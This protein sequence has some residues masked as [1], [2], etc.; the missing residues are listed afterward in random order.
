MEL[1]SGCYTVLC[2]CAYARTLLTAKLH[3]DGVRITGAPPQGRLT[4][5]TPSLALAMGAQKGAKTKGPRTTQ[6][7]RSF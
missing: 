1:T 3:S 4:N 7:W 5:G 2:H 6:L